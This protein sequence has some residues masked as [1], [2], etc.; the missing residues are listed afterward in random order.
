MGGTSDLGVQ[1]RKGPQG[2]K[3]A[4][5]PAS[6]ACSELMC[7]P[8]LGRPGHPL[9]I[10]M[11]DVVGGSRGRTM[12]AGQALWWQLLAPACPACSELES[13][14]GVSGFGSWG[15]YFWGGSEGA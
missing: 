2:G 6:P 15:C 9:E 5:P 12:S 3:G 10:G 14:A 8:S 7:L 13:A 4:P 11:P 1:T